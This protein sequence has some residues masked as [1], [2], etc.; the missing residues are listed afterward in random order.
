M[1]KKWVKIVPYICIFI[2]VGIIGTYFYKD[3]VARIANGLDAIYF[4]RDINPEH[5][6]KLNEEP[7]VQE[8]TT[9]RDHIAKLG[10]GFKRTENVENIK[11]I[12]GLREKGKVE[13]LQTW[14]FEAQDISQEAVFHYFALDDIMVGKNRQMEILVSSE[15]IEN[16]GAIEV[17]TSNNLEKYGDLSYRGETKKETLALAIVGPV[18]YISKLF[19]VMVIA[20]AFVLC[21]LYWIVRRK[22]IPL[23]KVFLVMGGFL[24]I[25]YLLLFT[26]YSEPDSRAHIAT[27]YY[28]A[29]IL[30]GKESL[31]EDGKTMV[32]EEDLEADGLSE[33]LGMDNLNTVKENIFTKSDKNEMVPY[34]RGKMSVP[35]S[36]FVPQIAGTA[37]GMLLKC[38][39]TLTLYLGK[40]FTLI[41]YL[42]C[43]YFAIKLIPFGKMV[44]F[45]CALLPFSLETATSYSYDATVIAL[46]FLMIGYV[47]Y[48]KYE[49]KKVCTSDIVLWTFL[50]M[51]L[52]PCKI[53][54]YFIGFLI[55]IVP[56][57][58]FKTKRHYYLSGIAA[59]GFG[60]IA[61]AVGRMTTITTAVE[62]E[63]G[64]YFTIDMFFED[65]PKSVLM[66]GRTI[67]Y[68]FEDYL[69]QIFGGLYSWMDLHLSWNFVLLYLILFCLVLL[70]RQDE[71]T[72]L[73]IHDK[74][75]MGMIVLLI[76]AMVAA[77]ML[78]TWTPP[79]A[80]VIVGIQGRYFLPI[81]P[82]AG[83][84]FR[85]K[86]ITVQKNIDYHLALAIM[87]IQYLTVMQIF[88]CTIRR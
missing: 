54:Y 56:V 72:F 81:L 79:D 2:L 44:L 78:F 24:G 9:T 67:N 62:G 42:I 71:K 46:S 16:E 50:T 25:V 70:K 68:H 8:F 58:K 39:G 73:N 1:K 11:V 32:R 57:E 29:D 30:T 51:W 83:F 34:I 5:T 52:A 36:A 12:V 82:L 37:L 53:V 6:L 31:S 35:A 76:S 7:I 61:L 28:Y 63:A 69:K 38:G 77:S 55:F 3:T 40:I 26:P 59:T 41:F 87:A 74:I 10:I 33:F 88:T 45:L 75:W 48:L 18:Q 23:E 86:T 43:C 13:C 27:A 47:F 85:N 14:E 21:S 66:I 20:F 80:S 17:Y 49:K 60:A 4:S 65:I 19:W 22:N 64:K 15:E 84:I